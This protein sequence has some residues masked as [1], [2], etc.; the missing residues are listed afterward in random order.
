MHH[1]DFQVRLLKTTS[2]QV[3]N[4]F[5]QPNSNYKVDLVAFHPCWG[6]GCFGILLKK[7]RFWLEIILTQIFILNH[8]VQ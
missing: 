3:P 5:K 2:V 1:K 6:L 4:Q 8:S 7:N